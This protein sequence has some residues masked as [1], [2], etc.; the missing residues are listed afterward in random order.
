M[1]DHNTDITSVFQAL[2]DQTRLRILILLHRYGELCVLDITQALDLPQ[3]KVS[4]HLARL[5]QAAL[6]NDRRDG[7]WVHYRLNPDSAPWVSH[8]MRAARQN[9]DTVPPYA[10][11]AARLASCKEEPRQGS[12]LSATAAPHP[13]GVSTHNPSASDH[14]H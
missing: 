13:I 5:R 9:T 6:V 4:R 2:S 8:L 11:D 3:P 10:T 14:S 12:P 1:N 7:V